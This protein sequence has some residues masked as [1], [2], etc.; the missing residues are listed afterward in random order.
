MATIQIRI[1]EKTKKSA[2]RVF[3][4]L[5]MD[6]SGAI[7]VY[8]KQV[9]LRQQIPFRL[10]TENGMTVEEEDEVLQAAEE[11]RRGINISEP[12]DAKEFS[13]YLRSL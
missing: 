1:D 3:D 5:G 13:A 6:M 2:K 11:A 12:M 4:K 10:L 7:N 8:L 9:V